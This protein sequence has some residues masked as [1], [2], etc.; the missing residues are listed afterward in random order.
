MLNG[1][2]SPAQLTYWSIPGPVLF[3]MIALVGLACFAYIVARRLT[4]LLRG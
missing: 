1:I 4:P 2:P 3:S